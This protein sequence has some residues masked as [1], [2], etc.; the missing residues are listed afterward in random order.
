MQ[1]LEEISARIKD[2]REFSDYTYAD[3]ARKLSIS[4]EEY[5]E[6]ESG[7]KDISIGTLYDIAAVLD[8]D[9]SVILCSTQI[10]S[11]VLWSR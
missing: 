1:H 7:Q 9:P 6:L 8:I 4:E 3:M 5:V 10:L 11:T 2:L